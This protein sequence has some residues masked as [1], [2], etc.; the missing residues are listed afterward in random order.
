MKKN[1]ADRSW[2]NGKLAVDLSGG[3]TISAACVECGSPN[4]EVTKHGMCEC[5]DCGNEMEV[6]E[7]NEKLRDALRSLDSKE[8]S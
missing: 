5:R 7:A 1:V 8:S 6:K 2:I 3:L 4:L